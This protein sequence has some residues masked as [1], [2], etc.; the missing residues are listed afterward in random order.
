ME[1]TTEIKP[2]FDRV[3]LKPCESEQAGGIIIPRSGDDRS[4]FMRVAAL[5]EGVAAQIKVGDKVII[6][7]FSGT[8]VNAAGEK[9]T[10]V[11]EY[12]LL[13]AV[14]ESEGGAAAAA[15]VLEKE[16]G[17]SAAVG[18]V[19][20]S[21]KLVAAGAVVEAGAEDGNKDDDSGVV[22]DG[23][24]DEKGRRQ[25]ADSGAVLES[26]KLVAAAEKGVF[27]KKEEKENE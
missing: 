6:A 15:A 3:L 25:D 12:D 19:L 17:R 18:A 22:S 2:L 20:E 13:G 16:G 9:F 10:L 21:G 8:E 23:N 26:G 4:Q 1:K 11:C 24:K 27:E 14:L 5:G 7:K